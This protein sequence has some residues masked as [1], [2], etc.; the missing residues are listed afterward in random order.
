MLSELADYSIDKTQSKGEC[1]PGNNTVFCN[2]ALKNGGR[3][4]VQ[5]TATN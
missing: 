3:R 4:A 1:K 2:L 5:Y